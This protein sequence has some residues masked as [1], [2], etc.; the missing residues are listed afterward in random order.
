VNRLCIFVGVTVFGLLGSLLAGAL[1]LE[2]F[3]LGGFLLSGIGSMV[4]VYV[5]W[6]VARRLD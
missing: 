5:G 3:S 4:G 2:V 1:G 6:K